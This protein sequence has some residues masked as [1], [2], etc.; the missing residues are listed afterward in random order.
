MKNYPL[1]L[2]L[3][4]WPI[5][6]ST[7]AD[8]KSVQVLS[9]KE[10]SEQID[11]LAKL[12]QSNAEEVRLLIAKNAESSSL[13]QVIAFLLI[14]GLFFEICGALLLAGDP[15]SQKMTLLNSLTVEKELGDLEITDENRLAVVSF[16]ALFGSIL[17][18]IGFN[19][20]F[21]A[22]LLSLGL[23][24]QYL[25][26]LI[27]FAF[28]VSLFVVYFLTGK[29]PDQTRREKWKIFALTAY[30]L[31][32]ANFLLRFFKGQIICDKCGRISASEE[33]KISYVCDAEKKE[34]GYRERPF[35][36]LIGH[37]KCLEQDDLN[38]KVKSRDQSDDIF[39]P[40]IA[41]HYR[42]TEEFIENDYPEHKHMI[43]AETKEYALNDDVL[44][45]PSLNQLN[46]IYQ[47]VRGF[48]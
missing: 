47:K 13:S 32:I 25:I 11:T 17:L 24:K 30:K 36:Y 45:S 42:T 26:L 29:N 14:I 38:Q 15:M 5:S 37:K 41:V 35:N 2:I 7:S 1:I 23:S 8:V 46:R 34:S 43:E 39:G 9:P 44:T 18:I 10:L 12:V 16:F 33:I 3:C 21:A 22:T 19:I 4:L 31:F 6:N 48:P 27:A 40:K 20:Q 28:F